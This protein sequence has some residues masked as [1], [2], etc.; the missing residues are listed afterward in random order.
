MRLLH[1]ERIRRRV[2]VVREPR[3]MLS[4]DL[5]ELYGVEHRAL[6]QAVQRNEARFPSDFMFRLTREE[7]QN[8]KSQSVIS[9]SGHG[10]ARHAPLAFT[11]QGVAMLSSVLKSPRAIAVNIEIMRAFVAVRQY[12]LG[13]RELSR[14]IAELR[15]TTDG[16]FAIVFDA[17]E[18]AA[19]SAEDAA[20]ACDRVQGMSVAQVAR[21]HRG[22]DHV[23]P[24]AEH[25]GVGFGGPA[26]SHLP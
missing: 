4:T 25:D 16:R 18:L 15:R 26:P 12:M 11:E 20:A 8:L 2:R 17:L 3:V 14:Q 13:N 23:W 1:F 10:G 22:I 5:A 7:A 9:S 6:F 21:R 24:R 19:H